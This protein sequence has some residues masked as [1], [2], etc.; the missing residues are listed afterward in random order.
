MKLPS[1]IEDQLAPIHYIESRPMYLFFLLT[2]DSKLS[3]GINNSR[4]GKYYD[5]K[6]PSSASN[7]GNYSK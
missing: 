2:S 5:G 1:A 7:F 4:P 3:Y 6:H